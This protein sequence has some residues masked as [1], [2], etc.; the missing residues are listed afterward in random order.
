MAWLAMA[1]IATL[2]LVACD[3]GAT[4]RFT[5]DTGEIITLYHDGLGVASTARR[6]SPGETY[7]EGKLMSAAAA[8]PDDRLREVGA[9]DASGTVVF[10]KRYSYNE[11]RRIE[12]RIQITRAVNEC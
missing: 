8:R 9:R 2:M 10:C 4:F 12:F 7:V 5:N 1:A 6:L 11:L 3:P